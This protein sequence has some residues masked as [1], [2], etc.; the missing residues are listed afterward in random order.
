MI[1]S[2]ALCVRTHANSIGHDGDDGTEGMSV[3]K[4]AEDES[5]SDAIVDILVK[6]LVVRPV[7]IAPYIL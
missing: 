5:L 7:I 6:S 2:T 1:H 3:D 4:V